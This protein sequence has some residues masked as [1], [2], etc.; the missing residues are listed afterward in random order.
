M[1]TWMVVEDEPGLYDMVL[2][3][4]DTL[5]IAGLAFAA[6]EEAIE[7]LDAV[8]GGRWD[9]E[10][11]ELALIDIRLP[12]AVDGVAVS[13]ALRDSQQLGDIAIVLMTAYHLSPTDE[14]EILRRSGADK[15]VYKPLPGLKQFDAL[16]RGAVADRQKTG[17]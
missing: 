13:A 1:T 12:G 11:P 5:G 10:L 4:Y 17:E 2:A 6:G 3:M 9:D 15:L 16:L 7:W 14:R 8:N